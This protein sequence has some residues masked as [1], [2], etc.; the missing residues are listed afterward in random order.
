MWARVIAEHEQS[1]AAGSEDHCSP[2]QESGGGGGEAVDGRRPPTSSSA[3]LLMRSLPV[4][5]L[6]VVVR[7]LCREIDGTCLLATTVCMGPAVPPEPNNQQCVSFPVIDWRDEYSD[8]LL[9]VGV[10]YSI[11]QN[12]LMVFFYGSVTQSAMKTRVLIREQYHCTTDH[13]AKIQ[14]MM[15]FSFSFSAGVVA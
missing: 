7:Q 15:Q 11:L 10:Q 14:Q 5:V 12:R 9:Y 3:C 1:G 4:S 6:H 13:S 8:L 2:A